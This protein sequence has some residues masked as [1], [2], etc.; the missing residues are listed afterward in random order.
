[1][2]LIKRYNNIRLILHKIYQRLC[3]AGWKTHFPMHEGKKTLTQG[4]GATWERGISSG[5]RRRVRWWRP[6][7][8]RWMENEATTGLDVER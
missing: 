8:N 2:I 1:M 7:R 6:G 4:D 5:G 3:F